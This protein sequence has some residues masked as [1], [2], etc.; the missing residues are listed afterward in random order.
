MSDRLIPGA[1]RFHANG[2]DGEGC[3]SQNVLGAAVAALACCVSCVC[4]DS[5]SELFH[6]TLHLNVENQT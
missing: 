6:N 3:E 5:L 4:A 2:I 1:G